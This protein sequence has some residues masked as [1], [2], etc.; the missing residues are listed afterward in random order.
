MQ[1]IPS[2][3]FIKYKTH[4]QNCSE[5]SCLSYTLPSLDLVSVVVGTAITSSLQKGVLYVCLFQ[6]LENKSV[7]RDG[8]CYESGVGSKVPLKV[9]HVLRECECKSHI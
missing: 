5:I 2:L 6:V 1:V 3:H 4:F 7:T 8:F 9:L